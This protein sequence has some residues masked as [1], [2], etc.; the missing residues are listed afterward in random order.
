MGRSST[1]GKSEAFK[2]GNMADKN[3]A[4]QQEPSVNAS[5]K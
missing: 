1:P 2:V 5:H 3:F 4:L